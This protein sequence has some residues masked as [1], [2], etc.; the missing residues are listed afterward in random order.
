MHENTPNIVNMI[1]AKRRNGPCDTVPLY[2]RS[3]LTRF[4]DIE[5]WREPEPMMS[6][7]EQ[8]GGE[9]PG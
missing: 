1:V 3:E 7:A 4:A 6:P 5:L 8:I 2:F 9:R